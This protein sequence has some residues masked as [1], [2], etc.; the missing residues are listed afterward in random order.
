MPLRLRSGPVD[1]QLTVR[2]RVMTW[3]ASPSTMDT[4][5][6]PGDSTLYEPE[7]AIASRVT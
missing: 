2:N 6:W 1:D 5:R 3:C 7:E 4:A